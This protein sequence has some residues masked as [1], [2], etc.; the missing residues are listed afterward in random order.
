[1]GQTWRIRMRRRRTRT[2]RKRRSRMRRSR[3]NSEWKVNDGRTP[4]SLHRLNLLDK[5]N[6]LSLP[7]SRFELIFKRLKRVSPAGG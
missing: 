3:K 4:A 2:R 1:M 6:R 7:V 5:P